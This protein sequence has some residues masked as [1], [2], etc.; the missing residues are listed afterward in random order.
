MCRP[1]YTGAT[2]VHVQT[3]YGRAGTAAQIAP[4]MPR[5]IILPP[6]FW[7]APP[8]IA[9]PDPVTEAGLVPLPAKYVFQ[10]IWAKIAHSR[11]DAKKRYI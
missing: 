4:M 1:G 5:M 11:E 8:D 7:G 3:G 2:R 9:P 10:I 6:A